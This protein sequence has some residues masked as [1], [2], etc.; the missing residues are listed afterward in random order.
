M[1]YH[2]YI[3]EITAAESSFQNAIIKRSHHT[4]GNMM[5][6]MLTGANLSNTFWIDALL[7]AV[8]VKNC[9]P[10]RA[11]T[12][13]PFQRFKGFKPNLS[14]FCVF[15]SKVNVKSQGLRSGKLNKHISTSIFF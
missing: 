8:Y 13:T 2:G 1:E 12:V 5:H 4:L 11:I 15:G 14:H 10:H 7:H 9:L 3:L 6:S